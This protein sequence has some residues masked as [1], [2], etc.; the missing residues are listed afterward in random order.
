MSWTLTFRP[1]AQDDFDKLDGTQKSLVIK[2]LTKVLKN[3]LPKQEGGYGEPLGNRDGI[4]LTGCLKIKMKKAGIRIVYTLE[5]SEE[6]MEVIIIGMRAGL[7][8][9]RDTAKRIGRAVK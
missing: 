2:R 9:Y 6:N 7:E 4:D 5:R 8:V 1:K 3:P